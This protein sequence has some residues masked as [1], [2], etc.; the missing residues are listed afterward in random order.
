MNMNIAEQ[1][2]KNLVENIVRETLNEEVSNAKREDSH[3]LCEMANVGAGKWGKKVYKLIVHGPLSGDR[4]TPH[5]HIYEYTER[6]TRNPRFNFEIS[7]EGIITKNDL[8]LS[9]QKDIE[10]NLLQTHRS[11]CSWTGY[12]DLKKDLEEYLKNNSETPLFGKT[13]SNLQMAIYGWNHETDMLL[14][15]QGVNIFGYYCRAKN[16]QVLPQYQSYLL[17]YKQQTQQ[18]LQRLSDVLASLV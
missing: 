12:R 15:E 9:L 6:N 18:S 10:N 11:Q 14:A 4:K 2:L 17:D 16:I 3:L 8:V 13:V 5:L 7:L 1:Y